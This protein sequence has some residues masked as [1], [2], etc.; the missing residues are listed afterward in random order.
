MKNFFILSLFILQGC[1]ICPDPTYIEFNYPNQ[2]IEV[3]SDDYFIKSVTVS[4]Y[5]LKKG[6]MELIDSNT[7]T[8]DQFG[9][10]GAFILNISDFGENYKSE[11]VK[12][13]EILRKENLQFE[14]RLE[15]FLNRKKRDGF[16]VEIISFIKEKGK[17]KVMYRS[18]HSCP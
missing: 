8:I 6:Y 12:L 4:E 3:L 17:K 14:I 11:N 9:A 10:R 18:K 5:T 1:W 2:T 13:K 16:D 7:V 15:K